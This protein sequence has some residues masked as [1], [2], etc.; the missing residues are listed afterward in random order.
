MSLLKRFRK[1]LLAN[2]L[3][4]RRSK[5][6]V[7]VSGGADSVALLSLLCSVADE[8]KLTLEVAHLDHALRE[9]SVMDAEFVTRLCAE[10]GLYLTQKRVDV[11]RVA[12]D[13]K[14]NLEEA[15]RD[16]R[17]NFL[18]E[19]AESR[20]CDFIVLGHHLNDQAETFLMRLIRGSGTKGLTGMSL[21]DGMLLRPL[22]SFTRDEIVSYLE[23]EGMSWREDESN[24]NLDF[25]RNRVRSQLVPMLE[26]FNPNVT[27]QI[28]TLAEQLQ[29]DELFWSD[30][31]DSSLASCLSLH[32]GIHVL[33][34]LQLI[35]MKAA[36]AS[37]VVRAVLQQ[38]RGTLRGLSYAHVNDVIKLAQAESP[39]AEL[40]LPDVW[41]ARRY[42]QI[43]FSK[44]RPIDSPP[45]EITITGFGIYEVAGGVLHVTKEDSSVGTDSW[46]A[47]FS[48]QDPLFPLLL[49]SPSHGDRMRPAGMQG[50]KKLQDLFVDLKKTRE[51]RQAALLLCKDEK[52]LW[53]VGIRRSAHFLPEPNEP[54]LRVVFVP[55]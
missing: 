49:R 41:V 26:S 45:I 3:L 51:E 1:S 10:Y 54:V 29:Q 50:R 20:S 15:A 42:D 35:E 25:M 27:Q 4:P 39:Q 37:R 14:G 9:E 40:D 18:I 21:N 23:S 53:V 13:C 2:N 17:R 5:L 34:R 16:I 52:I 33:D 31:I 8:F 22:L 30:Y 36:V 19:T 6:L 47:E 38:V 32:D 48:L 44:S 12:S 7:A 24:R 43:R 46:S 11:A 55:G 28:A